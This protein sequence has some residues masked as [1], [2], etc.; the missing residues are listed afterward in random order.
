MVMLSMKIQYP[1]HCSNEIRKSLYQT[2]HAKNVQKYII[3]A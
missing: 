3:F 2:I 1:Y